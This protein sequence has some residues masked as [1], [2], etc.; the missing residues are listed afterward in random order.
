MIFH[1][2]APVTARLELWNGLAIL[3]FIVSVLIISA[4]EMPILGRIQKNGW[5]KS[6]AMALF[7]NL[8]SSLLNLAAGFLLQASLGRWIWVFSSFLLSFVTEFGLLLLIKKQSF[9]QNALTALA[10]NLVSYLLLAGLIL[11]SRF[12]ST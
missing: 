12:S 7:L 1:F 2:S 3:S 11:L 9:R 10:I 5:R 8:V 6:F 4:V